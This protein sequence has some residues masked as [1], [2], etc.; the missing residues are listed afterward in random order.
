MAKNK[1]KETS[2]RIHIYDYLTQCKINR[3]QHDILMKKFVSHGLRTSEEW[4][5]L[6]K[7]K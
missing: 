1:D 5:E 7:V 4:E 6:T 3:T 2:V